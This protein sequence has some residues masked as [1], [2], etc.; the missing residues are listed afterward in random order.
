MPEINCMLMVAC[1]AL[2]IGF[3]HS[4]ALAAAYGIAVTGTMS[5]TSILF[6]VLVR[7]KWKWSMGRSLALCGVF[8]FVD[9]LF[10]SANTVKLAEGGWVPLGIATFVFTVMVTWK[11]GRMELGRAIALTTLPLKD[12]LEDLERTKP[13]RVKGTAVFMTSNPD[14]APPVLLHHFKHN[15][16]LHEQV[17]CLS[18][19]THHVPEVPPSARLDTLKDLGQGVWQVRAS[20]GFMQMPSAPEILERCRER[21]LVTDVGGHE[22]LP[23][24]RD[25][26]DHRPQG[27]GALAEGL[28]RVLV[29]ERA[30]GDG[31]LSDPA[32]SGGGVRRADRAVTAC[33][34]LRA[35]RRSPGRAPGSEARTPRRGAS[36]G[37]RVG[38]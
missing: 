23:R 17:V 36:S 35:R 27:D 22:L 30:A 9:L 10:L 28:V 38:R 19:V 6:F 14:A 4:D 26:R 29:A 8:L 24:P 34:E 11:R 25:A 37:E 2:V 13:H 21:G 7:E 5:I 18:I 33:G 16:V 12:F 31:V 32:E 20:Y 3:K 1:V 15:K